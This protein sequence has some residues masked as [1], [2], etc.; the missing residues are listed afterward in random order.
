MIVPAQLCYYLEKQM[1]PPLQTEAV[2][3]KDLTAGLPAESNENENIL[4]C[5]IYNIHICGQSVHLEQ[6]DNQNNG[7][8]MKMPYLK[9][10]EPEKVQKL[11]D[12]VSAQ[13]GQI[14][15]KTL[16]QNPAVSLT[17][18]AFDQGE[19]IGT[20]DSNGDALVTVLEGTGQ[21]TVD[22]RLHRCSAGESLIMPAK[23]PHAV[24]AVEPFKMLLTVVF[25]YAE[26]PKE[27][28]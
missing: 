28:E 23:K 10:M 25:P 11:A 4:I 21:F 9:N 14:V 16:A 7:R 2:I 18:F 1:H 8:R 20:H 17:L 6:I 5:W 22:G 27:M 26:L 19:E 15:S 13:P 12:L 3:D 24:F